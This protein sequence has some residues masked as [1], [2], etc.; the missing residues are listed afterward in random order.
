MAPHAR[1]PPPLSPSSTCESRVT[2]FRFRVSSFELWVSGFGFRVSG[3]R[4]GV[5]GFGFRVSGFRSRGSTWG[6][7]PPLWLL[8]A[9]LLAHTIQFKSTVNLTEHLLDPFRI[10]SPGFRVLNLG[11]FRFSVLG[12]RFFGFQLGQFSVFRGGGTSGS[13]ALQVSVSGFRI[14]VFGF[15]GG[16]HLR[17]PLLQPA[18]D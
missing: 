13:P 5:S 6:A 15:K 16:A 1:P 12:S 9:A 14:S 11:T 17:R 8:L 4:F 3:F 2:G 18:L 10:S 7:P